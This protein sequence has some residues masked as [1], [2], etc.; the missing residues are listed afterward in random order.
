MF[1]LNDEE[2]S[3]LDREAGEADPAR[4]SSATV[5][6]GGGRTDHDPACPRFRSARL[7][8]E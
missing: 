8:H 1:Y 2:L 5:A 7:A 6:N 3:R 4:L